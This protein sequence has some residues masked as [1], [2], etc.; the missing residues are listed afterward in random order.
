MCLIV[1]K[2]AV[3]ETAE[4]DILCY[5]ITYK[6]RAGHFTHI[7]DVQAYKYK[8]GELQPYVNVVVEKHEGYL[9]E[10]N[11]GYHSFADEPDKTRGL[12]NRSFGVFVIPKG[13]QFIK[14]TVNGEVD[15]YTSSTLIYM[16]VMGH[17]VT[18]LRLW[19]RKQQKNK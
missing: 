1:D 5:K 10:V 15:G 7:S 18:R 14:G 6:D 12:A 8:S 3:I 11:E 4:E 16:G 13:S 17:P 2:D 9:P 19:D